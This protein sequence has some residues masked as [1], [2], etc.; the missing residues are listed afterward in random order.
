MHYIF[1]TQNA[2]ITVNI[3]KDNKLNNHVLHLSIS[4]QILIV[5]LY[6][7]TCLYLFQLIDVETE[8]SKLVYIS[9]ALTKIKM[10][11]AQH[12]IP[13]TVLDF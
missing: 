4:H 7:I 1:D 6:D 11:W 5:L 12:H 10:I 9:N 2:P 3:A 13:L 8:F